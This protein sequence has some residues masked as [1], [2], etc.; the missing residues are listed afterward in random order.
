MMSIFDPLL[1]SFFMMPIEWCLTSQIKCIQQAESTLS[2][3][4]STVSTTFL[5]FQDGVLWKSVRKYI[6]IY[7]LTEIKANFGK[8]YC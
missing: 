1:W 7:G 6:P 4:I 8:L 3:E 5:H 2:E